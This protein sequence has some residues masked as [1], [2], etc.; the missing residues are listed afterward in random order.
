MNNLSE[1]IHVLQVSGITLAGVLGASKIHKL[2]PTKSSLTTDLLCS[3]E[4][5]SRWEVLL[6][7]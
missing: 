3:L 5:N 2:L 6:H 4:V 1:A 7:S